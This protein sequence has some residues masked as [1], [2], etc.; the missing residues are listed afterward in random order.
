[1]L[2]DRK[3][4]CPAEKMPFILFAILVQ[5]LKKTHPPFYFGL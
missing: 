4:R 1:M 5:V 2:S 3:K